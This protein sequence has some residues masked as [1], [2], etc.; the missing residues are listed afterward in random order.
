MNRLIEDFTQS[1]Y[2]GFIVKD[3]STQGN[4]TA[5]LVILNKQENLLILIVSRL[6][7]PDV[8]YMM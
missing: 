1:L 6:Q 3:V 8:N 5:K 4:F 7:N 2:N